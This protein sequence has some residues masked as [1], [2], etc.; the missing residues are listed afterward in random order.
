MPPKLKVLLSVVFTSLV[1][2]QAT[3]IWVLKNLAPDGSKVVVVKNWVE[4]IHAENK[5]AAWSTLADSP[6]RL[7]VFAAFTIVAVIALL[8]MFRE[9]EPGEKLRAASTGL[10]LS[11][12][13]G[14]AIDRV[15]KG[16]VTDFIK[17]F[18]GV[19]DARDWLIEHTGT[20]VWPIFN[21]ADAAIVTGVI[22]FGLEYLFQRDKAP[23]ADAIG[24]DPLKAEGRSDG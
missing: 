5:G 9:L 11:G 16:S 23:E 21:I 17:V 7:Y 8:Q 13:L 19:G 12:A 2:D 1:L 4:F 10:I 14:N 18:A 24:P 6:Y 22:L 20:N 3:K 15:W